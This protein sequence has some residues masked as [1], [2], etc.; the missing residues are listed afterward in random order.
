MIYTC[1]HHRLHTFPYYDLMCNPYH[2]WQLVRK[3]TIQ[4]CYRTYINDWL[5]FFANNCRW[6]LKMPSDY[7]H[8]KPCHY[9]FEMIDNCVSQKRTH[10]Y[11]HIS[12]F[13]VSNKIHLDMASLHLVMVLES[14]ETSKQKRFNHD[15]N[16]TIICGFENVK[17]E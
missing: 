7:V 11:Q 8:I 17:I 16:H 13:L 5:C 14:A 12:H 15:W 1:I 6:M 4:L 9:T 2:M 3:H 10:L